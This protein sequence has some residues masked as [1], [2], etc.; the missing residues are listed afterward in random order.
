MRRH[1]SVVFCVFQAFPYPF[2]T[3]PRGEAPTF[4]FQSKTATWL[5]HAA[6]YPTNSLLLGRSQECMHSHLSKQWLAFWYTVCS[7]TLYETLVSLCF[8]QLTSLIAV[9][10]HCELGLSRNKLQLFDSTGRIAETGSYCT[11]YILLAVCYS[12]SLL[13]W[14]RCGQCSLEVDIFACLNKGLPIKRAGQLGHRCSDMC[15][16]MVCL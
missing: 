5:W 11:S 15:R 16:E 12:T 7:A 8:L 10:H 6:R 14:F 3:H 4:P 2:H 13:S 1:Q 9:K